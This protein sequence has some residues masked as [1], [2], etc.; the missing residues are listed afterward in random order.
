MMQIISL[1]VIT[2]IGLLILGNQA[3][4]VGDLIE[5]MNGVVRTMMELVCRFMP[6]F[7]FAS[8][9]GQF[10]SDSLIGIFGLRKA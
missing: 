9:L 3:S 1:A 6:L 5:D 10:W 4:R 2:G 7:A 8:L